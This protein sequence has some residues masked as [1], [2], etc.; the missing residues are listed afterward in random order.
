M[1]SQLRRALLLLAGM[2]IGMCGCGDRGASPVVFLGHVAAR[3]GVDK[4]QGEAAERGIRLA[5]EEINKD[6]A[7]GAGR[8]V[9]VL[10]TDTLG[11]L[12]A[13]ETQA[14]RLVTV[15]RVTALLAGITPD[16]AERLD[17]ARVPLV[18]LAGMR[19]PAT[20]D[21]VFCTGLTP[22]VQGKALARYAVTDMKATSV[23]VLADDRR[24]DALAAAEAFERE[25]VR[26]ATGND[27]KSSVSRPAVWRFGRESKLQDLAWRLRA[28]DKP[29][30]LVFAGNAS[31]V[32]I[33]RVE[34]SDST[35][36]I[37]YAGDIG[38]LKTL[39]SERETS[40]GVYLVTPFVPDADT[41]K[42]KEFAKRYK[43][44]FA[45][46]PTVHAALAY[47]ALRLLAEALRRSQELPSATRLSDELTGL[48]DYAGLSGPL[49]F[50]EGRC[51]RR[52]AFVV[53][54]TNGSAKTVRRYGPEEF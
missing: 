4:E 49:S 52:T 34:L 13:F 35:T 18:T 36:P 7:L 47:D 11:K 16:E 2:T 21:A 12:E 27:G 38:A 1:N 15:N 5:V 43:E 50:D 30:A 39:Q 42:T 23:I 20:S 44:A 14:I 24:D 8:P 41:A 28:K 53:Q 31:D 48:K 40:G 32:R 19:T 26:A 17:R 6:P 45:D 46:E 9:K 33:L 3:S 10:H 25:F 29:S 54:V 51:L 22:T 37:L